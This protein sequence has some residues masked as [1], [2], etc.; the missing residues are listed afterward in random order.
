M[1]AKR[2]ERKGKAK[3]LSAVDGLLD[4]TERRVFTTRR[5]LSFADDEKR[6][7]SGNDEQED[8]KT[9]RSKNNPSDIPAAETAI[10][11]VI[12][13]RGRRGLSGRCRARDAGCAGADSKGRRAAPVGDR[14]GKLVVG[15]LKVVRGSA[16]EGR[17]KGSAEV[18]VRD[19]KVGQK[20]Q[21]GDRLRQVAGD[22][23]EFKT[24]FCLQ[25]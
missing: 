19:V 18:V 1:V 17:G 21:I 5:L 2:K 4:G 15:G 7:S 3:K 22:L 25:R 13:R 14:T 11:V 8:H 20:G 10:V 23:V 9:E 16:L 12:I 6:N 24:A